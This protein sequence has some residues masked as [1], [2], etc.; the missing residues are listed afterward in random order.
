MLLAKLAQPGILQT[1]RFGDLPHW[2]RPD[3]LI[4][5]LARQRDFAR[6]LSR[7]HLKAHSRPLEVT[8]HPCPGEPKG[9]LPGAD[10]GRESLGAGADRRPRPP[11][12][13]RRPPV[14]AE[15]PSPPDGSGRRRRPPGSRA[16]AG[17][18]SRLLPGTAAP[19]RAIAVISPAASS[20]AANM[21]LGRSS[22][23]EGGIDRAEGVR[24]RCPAG[25]RSHRKTHQCVAS[26]KSKSGRR[27]AASPASAAD[28]QAPSSG[29]LGARATGTRPT[30]A[31]RASAD[32]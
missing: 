13:S 9:I 11:R 32:R 25:R 1:Q 24:G 7:W 28:R 21:A 12:P 20:G 15:I 31:R 5:L 18:R 6:P 3:S 2:R 10:E 30:A 17:D 8:V 27:Y 22:L 26:F 19:P 4:E 23:P 16:G 14:A 29:F